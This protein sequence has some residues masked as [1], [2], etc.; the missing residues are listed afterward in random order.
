VGAGRERVDRTGGDADSRPPASPSTCDHVDMASP[1][2]KSPVMRPT[3]AAVEEFLAAVPDAQRQADARRL[4]ALMQEITG[5]PP[6]MWGPSIVGF[7]SYHYRYDSGREGDSP[8][9]GFSPRKQ[10]LV[11]YLVGGYETRHR[12]TLARLGPHKTGKSC[13]YLKRLSDV[14]VAALR[15]LIDRSVRVGRGIDRSSA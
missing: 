5:E 4:C 15:E 9:A 2:K 7:G 12:S 11:V 6:T 1:P 10:H 14:D 8:L 3:G 13:L